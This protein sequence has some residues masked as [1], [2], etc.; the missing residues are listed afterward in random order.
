MSRAL[1]ALGIG[2]DVGGTS[3]RVVVFGADD[4]PVHHDVAPTALGPE[5]L[6]DDLTR[7]VEAAIAAVP[8]RPASI[9]VGIPGGVR[10]GVVTMALNVG[11]DGR[12]DLAGEL[13]HRVGLPVHVEN[14]VNAAALGA[15]V[16]LDD[17][18]SS[19][20][21]LSIG[22]G[23]AAGTVID[24][25]IV[26]GVSG[27][28]GEIGHVPLPGRTES[29]VCGQTGCVE[30]IAS[31][32]SV[33]A[34][35]RAAGLDGGVVELF[36]AAE[37]DTT[38]SAIRDDMVS[39]LAWSAQLAVLLNDVE[40]VVLG[41]GVALALGDRLG[42]AVRSLLAEREASAPFLRSLG[43]A[44]RVRVAPD[45]IEFGALGAHRAAVDAGV[46]VPT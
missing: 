29:C 21:Y 37:H 32:R 8:D 34:T 14:D 33:V 4:R 42:D 1:P 28:A 18:G 15:C 16:A 9:G 46:E 19:L 24:G 12:L 36:D 5:A 17:I 13:A 7:R 35:M 31:G 38:A 25:H 10:S 2:I 11:I 20:T 27:V 23:I 30:A 26:R 22:T 3:T 45:G 44:A 40:A 39:A 6:L 43:L 41:G